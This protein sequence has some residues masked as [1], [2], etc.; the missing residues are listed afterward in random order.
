MFNIRRYSKILKYISTKLYANVMNKINAIFFVLLLSA[1]ML[2]CSGT[3]KKDES[4]KNKDEKAGLGTFP[5]VTFTTMRGEELSISDLRGKVVFVNFWATWCAPCRRE[6][7]DF[8][9]FQ[10]KYGGDNFTILGVSLDEQ[11]FEVVEPYAKEMGINYPLVVDNQN[12]GDKLGGIY[13]VPTTYFLD[14]EGN[15]TGRKIGYF[16]EDQMKKQIDKMVN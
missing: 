14:E 5:D 12:L 16:P 10:K 13:A 6:I 15:I 8:I 4:S 11:G 3:E 2:S 7:P 9:S 1:A